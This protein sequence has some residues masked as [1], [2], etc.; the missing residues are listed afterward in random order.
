[1]VVGGLSELRWVWLANM[2]RKD[3]TRR[4]QLN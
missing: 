1:M 4:R 3:V 2:F